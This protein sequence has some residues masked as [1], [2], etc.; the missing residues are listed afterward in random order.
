MWLLV[1]SILGGLI[2]AL[3]M[4]WLLQPQQPAT[5][6]EVERE[7]RRI[8]LHRSDRDGV[9]HGGGI[10]RWWVSATSADEITGEYRNFRMRSSSIHLAAKSA[11]LKVDPD[12]NA[13]R[14]ELRD[15]VFTK[16]PDDLRDALDHSLLERETYVLGPV[17]YHRT[18]VRDADTGRPPTRLEQLVGVGRD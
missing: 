2:F 11:V 3:G 15:V 18:I 9:E 7:I 5:V 12:R 4:I 17:P 6:T 13:I 10:G 1:P 16:V 8:L 14:F